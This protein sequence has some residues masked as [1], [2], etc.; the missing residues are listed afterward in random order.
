[1][2]LF[3]F[4]A[5]CDHYDVDPA[6]VYQIAG[7]LTRDVSVP[8]DVVDKAISETGV[9]SNFDIAMKTAVQDVRHDTRTDWLDSEETTDAPHH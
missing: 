8:S 3:P 7:H 1:M 6:T 5:V 2:T 9:R 4:F